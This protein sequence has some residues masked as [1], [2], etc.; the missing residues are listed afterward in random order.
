MSVCDPVSPATLEIREMVEK[1]IFREKTD[2]RSE[3]AFN[4]K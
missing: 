2:F 1:Y 4:E 3:N